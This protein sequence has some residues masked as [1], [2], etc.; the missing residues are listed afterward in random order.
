MMTT[1]AIKSK[2]AWQAAITW[3]KRRYTTQEPAKS[4][5]RDESPKKATVEN[6][7]P[8]KAMVEVEHWVRQYYVEP[9]GPGGESIRFRVNHRKGRRISFTDP[10]ARFTGTAGTT[11]M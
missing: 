3:R 5:D 10:R 4:D 2:P 7:S 9:F 8:K 1:A 11:G 6:K